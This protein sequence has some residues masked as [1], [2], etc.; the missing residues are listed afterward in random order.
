MVANPVLTPDSAA[1]AVSGDQFQPGN[2]I[3]D[4]NFFSNNAMSEAQVQAFF[5]SVTCRPSGG[6]PCLKDFRADTPTTPAAEAGHCTE[7]TGAAGESA[8]RIVWKVAQACRIN[9]A[10][11]IVLMQKEQSLVSSPS[12]YGY[13]RAMGWGCP[14]SGPNWSANCDANYFGLFNQVYKSAWQFRQYTLYP[15]NIP[16]G[17]TRRYHVGTVG[18]QFSPDPACGSSAVTI[19]NQATANLYL[20][21]PY[22]PNSA[23]LNNLYGT[24]DGCSAYGNRNFWRIYN[25]WFGSTVD[26]PGTP[27]GAITAAVGTDG[28]I[29]VKGWAVDP[30]AAA[31]SLEI[32]T[33]VDG[34]W[35]Y[36]WSAN[37]SDP[38]PAVSFPG[39]GGNHGWSATV[40]AAPAG[41]HSLCVYAVNRGAGSDL[42]IGCQNVMVPANNSP[43]GAV[44]N[45][46]VG[47]D[48]VTVSGW[49]TD[50]DAQSSPVAMSVW[51]DGLTNQRFTADTS[52]LAYSAAQAH[53]PGAGTNHGW[54]G[55]VKTGPGQHSLC[56]YA[57]NQNTGADVLESCHSVFVPATE[58]SPK[59]HVDTAVP[60]Q[61]GIALTGWAVDPDALTSPVRIA[62][63]LD[64]ATNVQVTA[65]L[66]SATA[67]AAYPGAGNLHGFSVLVP[68]TAGVHTV[69]VYGFNQNAG[70]DAGFSCHTVT[71]PQ[72]VKDMSPKGEILTNV[73][74]AGGIS[75]TGWAIDPDALT[76]PV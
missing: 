29:A 50:P 72:L 53:F 9:P 76:S 14:D 67:A 36:R 8:A 33:W 37:S 17:G 65:N 59:G 45:T 35:N 38:T 47:F 49:A 46:A 3:S 70:A 63:W 55:R 22:Q 27:V 51:V 48:G 34:L 18:V 31:D 23:A 19:L 26:P 43:Q 69:C 75:L 54:S 64:S 16:G 20:Y 10:V 41:A 58:P 52:S 61:G 7:Y 15:V 56:V 11:L 74:V 66:D 24:G 73:G 32:S 68:A 71:V 28:G 1:F 40:P 44:M 5:A 42:L 39:A 60:V 6:V 21:T 2:I 25:D 57:V 30:D 12:V 4:Q 62:A 13:A